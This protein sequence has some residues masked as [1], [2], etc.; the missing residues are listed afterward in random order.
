MAKFIRYWW[1]G[2]QKFWCYVD[3][4]QTLTIVVW[5][6]IGVLPLFIV[7]L[8]NDLFCFT[9]KQLWVLPTSLVVSEQWCWSSFKY[10]SCP[11][12]TNFSHI[13]ISHHWS[14]DFALNLT[15]DNF[16]QYRNDIFR[17]HRYILLSTFLF[18]LTSTLT[19]YRRIILVVYY[20]FVYRSHLR[21][22]PR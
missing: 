2:G 16:N 17:N 5:L 6:K 9:L 4:K 10:S 7:L 18:L 12:S 1:F 14:D 11:C 22:R 8:L 13:L 21:A 20:S 3:K 15:A 19:V